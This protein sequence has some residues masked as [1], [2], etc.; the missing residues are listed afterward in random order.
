[1][2][3]TISLEMLIRIRYVWVVKTDEPFR[4]FNERWKP[5]AKNATAPFAKADPKKTET[6]AASPVLVHET[7]A[8]SNDNP[9]ESANPDPAF[10]AALKTLT[11]DLNLVEIRECQK[12][13]QATMADRIDAERCKMRESMAALAQA[14]GMS[15]ADIVGEG[16]S[17]AGRKPPKYR[18]PSEP[19]LTWAGIGATPGW[20]KEALAAGHSKE[21][22]LIK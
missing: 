5:M 1:M 16:V 7:A 4:N 6:K 10:I 8:I 21:S 9:P 18:S 14:S 15:I 2:V 19:N 17:R 12:A 20:F 13:L 22:M 11:K 3:I